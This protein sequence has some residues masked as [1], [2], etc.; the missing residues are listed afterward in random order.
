MPCQA[1]YMRARASCVAK[2]LHLLEELAKS[3]PLL[4]ACYQLSLNLVFLIRSGTIPG[5][6]LEPSRDSAQAPRPDEGDQTK[7]D[8]DGK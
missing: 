2:K 4:V 8:R 3:I 1:D 6:L 7:G 5:C